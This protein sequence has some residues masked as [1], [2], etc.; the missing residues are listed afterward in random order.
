MG[1]FDRF[2]PH[3]GAEVFHGRRIIIFIPGHWR[4]SPLSKIFYLI[5]RLTE[6][7]NLKLRLR[8]CENPDCR[9]VFYEDTR[10]SGRQALIRLSRCDDIPLIQP[11]NR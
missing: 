7:E 2:V 5:T 1:D 3:S 11:A 9:R 4:S 8:V 6:A 10:N